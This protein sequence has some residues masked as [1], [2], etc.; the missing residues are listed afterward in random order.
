MHLLP[1]MHLLSV[2]ML[3]ALSGGGGGGGAGAGAGA[4]A[5]AAGGGGGGGGGFTIALR[6]MLIPSAR[7]GWGADALPAGASTLQQS[8]ILSR[9]HAMASAKHATAARS[10]LSSQITFT[11]SRGGLTAL[12]VAAKSP[13]RSKLFLSSQLPVQ[14]Y[15]SKFNFTDAGS[16]GDDDGDDGGGGG[17][18]D[19]G[20]YFGPT[21]DHPSQDSADTQ[22]HGWASALAGV[23]PDAH[24]HTS[25]FASMGGSDSLHDYIAAALRTN[26]CVDAHVFG[27]SPQA[28]VIAFAQLCFAPWWVRCMLHSPR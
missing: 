23:G 10:W 18:D 20:D 9:M 26:A 7:H 8:I 19:G 27:Y 1:A 17:D 24:P 21:P 11:T 2:A 16:G 5:A 4:G 14:T 12:A 3:P 6:C 22:E 25:V 28:N 15:I 13:H